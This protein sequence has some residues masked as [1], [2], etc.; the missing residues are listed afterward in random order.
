MAG[1]QVTMD[2]S[3]SLI[4][5]IQGILGASMP[6]KWLSE[7]RSSK[8]TKVLFT[9]WRTDYSI[10]SPSEL[11]AQSSIGVD[12]KFR[13]CIIENISA[14][15]I[16]A[17]G[18]AWNI[19]AQFFATHATNPDRSKLWLRKEW[20][21]NPPYTPLVNEEEAIEPT[22]S[23]IC[24]ISPFLQGDCD[25]LD[26]IFEYNNESPNLDPSTLQKLSTSP[27]IISRHCFKDSRWPKESRWPIQSNT[28]ISYCRPDALTCKYNLPV[29]V[30]LTL[31]FLA[32]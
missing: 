26:G 5:D 27:N 11:I 32:F 15:Y 7:Q 13:V 8:A 12:S 25:Y 1:P 31:M 24:D 21:W 30:K 18:S 29:T 20:D 4:R 28:R 2:A 14:E 10:N 22:Q 17:L 19:D 23:T 3:E 9:D 16:E 6:M